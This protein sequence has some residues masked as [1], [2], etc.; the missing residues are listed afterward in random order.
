MYLF[1]STMIVAYFLQGC[2]LNVINYKTA[3]VKEQ[4]LLLEFCMKCGQAQ[5]N[6]NKFVIMEPTGIAKG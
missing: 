2:S 6:K 3:D 5:S 1:V 4:H